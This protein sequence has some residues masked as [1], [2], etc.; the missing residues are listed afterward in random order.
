[1]VTETLVSNHQTTRHKNPENNKC[2][3]YF[4]FISAPV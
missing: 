3:C 2:R 1:M 4:Q